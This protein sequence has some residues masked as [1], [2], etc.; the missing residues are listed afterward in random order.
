[1]TSFLLAALLGASTHMHGWACEGSCTPDLT[2]S[3]LAAH[4]LVDGALFAEAH[5]E[6][7]KEPQV[8]K[9]SVK[10]PIKILIYS[11]TD[12]FR[13]DSIEKGAAMFFDLAD[14]EG[15]DVTWTED[16]AV[17]NRA[18]I[19]KQN[20]VIFLNTTGDCVTPEGEAAL[21]EFIEKK[22]GGFVGIHSAA[23]TEYDWSWYGTLVG[24]YFK[25]H[26]QI[27]PAKVNVVDRKHPATKHLPEVWART[28]EW[29]DYRAVPASTVRILMK[30][31]TTSY[32]GHSMGDNHPTAWCHEIG[33]GRAF[34]TGGGHTRESYDDPD[35]RKHLIGAVRWAAKKEKG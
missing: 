3:S 10:N 8:K 34:Y 25:S 35:F 28:D 1:M 23:D 19:D 22:G 27:Q 31:D 29:Y 20:V 4:Q 13:H 24:A 7:Q 12:G 21:T 32:S 6:M 18:T 14:T 26:P 15:F 30:L 9:S 11:R 17:F 16:K 33:K 5:P 2:P